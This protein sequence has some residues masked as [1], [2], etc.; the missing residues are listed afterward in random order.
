MYTLTLCS[1]D[2]ND[3]AEVRR[4]LTNKL[5]RDK[6]IKF[7]EIYHY[8]FQ[9]EEE[10][11][12]TM[13]IFTTFKQRKKARIYLNRLTTIDEKRD[14]FQRGLQDYLD[15]NRKAIDIRVFH[16]NREVKDMPDL[17]IV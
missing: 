14:E 7:F 12:C 1:N 11:H 9:D 4:A 3:Y 2:Y 5:V 15:E 13:F 10:L 8:N 6:D 16:E 17:R